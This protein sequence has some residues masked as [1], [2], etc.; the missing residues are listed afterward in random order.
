MSQTQPFL[1][2]GLQLPPQI[3]AAIA[4]GAWVLPADPDLLEGVFTEAS[5]AGAKLYSLD[6]MVRENDAWM[7]APPEELQQY[8]GPGSDAAPYLTV[9]PRTSVLI[10][11]LGHDMPIALDYSV[12]PD[13]P[14]VVYL[15]S[16]APG[17][18]EVAADMT[19][20]MAALGIGSSG[21]Q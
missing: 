12:S 14:R 21:G 15:P 2:H 9:E 8:G 19:S 20:F 3:Q 16:H 7:D 10:G 13:R 11:D 6:L 1:I 5:V 17:W 18:I 4:D